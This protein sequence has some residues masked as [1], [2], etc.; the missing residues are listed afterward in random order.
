MRSIA[1]V[2]LALPL[3]LAACATT[4]RQ[5]CEAPY[6]AE[7][8]N[9]EMDIRDTR[10]ALQRGFALVPARFSFGL[11]HCLRPSGSVYLCTEDDGEPMYDKRPINRRAE[12]AKLTALDS[13]AER[14][15]AAIGAC[16]ARYPE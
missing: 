4:P 16:R 11:H 15:K 5:K 7:L 10:Q 13:E 3:L 1:V 2:A 8:R 14:L 12:Q 9:V 6:R